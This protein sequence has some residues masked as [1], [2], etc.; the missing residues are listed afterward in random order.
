MFT[1]TLKGS[2]LIAMPHMMDG[3]FAHSLVYLCE[4]SE[5]GAMGLIVNKPLVGVNFGEICRQVD[6]PVPEAPE[7]LVYYGGPVYPERGFILHSTEYPVDSGT[8]QVSPSICLSAN[9]AL[10]K[11]IVEGYGPEKFLLAMGYSGWRPGQ[12]ENEIGNDDWL[13][14]P[15]DDQVI[16]DVSNEQKWRTA[17]KLHGIDLSMISN[18]TGTA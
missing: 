7:P 12:L 9:Q 8:L 1:Q 2:F 10:L 17:A 3:R 13:V 16:F 14:L 11:D 18:N 6:L 5:E 4:H 15:A